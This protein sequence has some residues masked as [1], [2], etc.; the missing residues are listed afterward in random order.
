MNKSKSYPTIH[1]NKELNLKK[2]NSFDILKLDEFYFEEFFE[3]DGELGIIFA[4]HKDNII[5][6]NIL[7]NTVAAET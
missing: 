3:G 4:E 7:P 5:V 2:S 6:K 1:E